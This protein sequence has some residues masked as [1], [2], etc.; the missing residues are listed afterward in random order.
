MQQQERIP[1][2]HSGGATLYQRHAPALF[3]YLLRQT[4]SREDAED[5][6]VEVFLAALERQNLQALGEQEQR[7]WLWTV[8]RNKSIDLHRRATRHPNVQLKQAG[9]TIYADD[10]QAPEHLVLRQE[11]YSQLHAHMRELSEAQQELLQLRFGHGLSCAEIATVM[12]KSEGAVRMLL[13]RTLRLL[14]VIYKKH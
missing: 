9:D 10:E 1:V 14:R 2:D 6:L 3:A 12:E 11:E 4:S 13:S 5:L 8:A 7:A